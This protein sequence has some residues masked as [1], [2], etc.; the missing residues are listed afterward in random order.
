MSIRF[1]VVASLLFMAIPATA[2]AAG[3]Q[4]AQ[5]STNPALA[6]QAKLPAI[7]ILS[8][9]PTQGEPAPRSHNSKVRNWLHP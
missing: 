3:K 8:I 1:A 5:K 6:D 2:P 4:L 9:V 7:S